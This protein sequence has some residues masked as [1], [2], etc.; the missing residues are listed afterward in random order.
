MPVTGADGDKRVN[1][2]E[3]ST[4]VKRVLSD[5]SYRQSA[6]RIAKSMRSYGGAFA[7]AQHL[8]EFLATH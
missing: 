2:A 6:Q 1:A 7:A 8:E 4:K 3:F 5:P